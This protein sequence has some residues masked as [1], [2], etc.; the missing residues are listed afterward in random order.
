MPSVYGYGR[1][2]EE[3]VLKNSIKEIERLFDSIIDELKQPGSVSPAA[4]FLDIDRN[5]AGKDGVFTVSVTVL[6]NGLSAR[7]CA[8]AMEPLNGSYPVEALNRA[9]REK[10]I[11]FGIDADKLLEMALGGIYNTEVEFARG[12]APVD[13]EDGRIVPLVELSEAGELYPVKAGTALCRIE[14]P[15][16]GINGTDVF[17]NVIR[18]KRGRACTAPTGLNTRLSA[19]GSRLVAG[20]SGTLA[21]QGGRYCMSDEFIVKGDV[22]RKNGK[23]D[24]FGNITVRGNVYKGAD[25]RCGGKIRIYGSVSDAELSAKSVEIAGECVNTR[26]TAESMILADCRQCG[27]RC[28]GTIKCGSLYEC[29]VVCDGDIFCTENYGVIC[30]GK[31]DCAGCIVCTSAGTRMHEKTEIILGN[32][33]RLESEKTELEE[34]LA[35]IDA[36]INKIEEKLDESADYD[37]LSE[38]DRELIAAAVRI[39]NRREEEREPIL[40]RIAKITEVISGAGGSSLRATRALHPGINVTIG[41][42]RREVEKEYAGAVICGNH[43]GIVIS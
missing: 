41:G 11:V 20:I 34:K 37:N 4:P 13:G 22:D 17:G 15:T 36:E 10:G 12:N 40:V 32:S 42:Y 6:E 7:I 28:M 21:P 24:F 26:I 1:A 18:A 19:D 31:I 23:L 29:D 43:L 16:L 30:G 33:V 38:H 2:L 8:T 25:I 39:K 35:N 27:L 14:P 3:T 5:K 9:I